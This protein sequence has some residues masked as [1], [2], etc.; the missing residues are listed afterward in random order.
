MKVK[1]QRTVD[2]NQIPSVLIESVETNAKQLQAVCDGLNLLILCLDTVDVSSSLVLIN[3]IR[4]T[5]NDVDVFLQECDGTLKG[6]QSIIDNQI[7][8]MEPK[9]N[10]DSDLE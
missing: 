3:K 5:M 2:F 4:T 1:L 6:Y 8:S 7:V 10:D 9:E